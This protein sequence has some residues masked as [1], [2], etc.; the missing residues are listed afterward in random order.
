MT[1]SVKAAFAIFSNLIASGSAKKEDFPDFSDDSVRSALTEFVAMVDCTIISAGDD[2]YLLPL[3]VNSEYHMTN[4]QIKDKYLA[5]RAN[6]IDI[7][8]LYFTVLVF[9]GEFYDSYQALKPTR[10]FITISFWLECIESRI[11]ALETI[12][13]EKLLELEKDY[14]YNWLGII[15]QWRATNIINENVKK[16]TRASGSRLS[17]METAKK[18]LLAENLAMDIGNDELIL[19]D[20]TKVIVQRFFMDYEYNRGILD[21]MYSYSSESEQGEADASDK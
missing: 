6:N 5:K 15:K 11:S 14:Q 12:G 1:D 2:I 10:E 19:T 18:F 7:Y 3:T 9:I 4:Q 16:Q 17:F 20:K 21:I 8:L 13:E